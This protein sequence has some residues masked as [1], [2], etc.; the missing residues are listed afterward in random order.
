VFIEKQVDPKGRLGAG[1]SVATTAWDFAR[2]LGGSEI[3]IAG[4]DLAYPNLKTHFRGARFEERANSLSGRFNPAEKWIVRALR[5]GIPFKA[6]SATGEP[7]LTDRRLSLYAAWFE[8]Q[9]RQYPQV[10]NFGVFRDGLEIAGLQSAQTDALLS[11]PDRR[12]EIDKR[13][14][15]ALL[16][17]EKEFNDGEQSR[18][19]ARRY[20]NAVSD[21][22][23]GLASIKKTAEDGASIAM[24]VLNRDL[25]AAQKD[26][27]I[28][29]LDAL[30]RRVTESEVKEVAGF[31]LP[32]VEDD[33]EKSPDGGND[34]F[35]TYLNSTLKLFSGLAQAAEID[36][37]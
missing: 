4:L 33:R 36:L 31:L 1:G 10:K 7:I 34:P 15:E 30:T 5:D 27:V 9:F 11:L 37:T 26:K 20:E 6:R 17:T 25:N 13:L 3:W 16:K 14:N 29:E 23:R 8:N 22:K 18:E 19:R 35:K 12:D 24:Q 32:L 21:L 2:I 28:K